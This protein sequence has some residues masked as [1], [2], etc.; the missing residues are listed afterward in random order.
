MMLT[1]SSDNG[2]I[3]E[4]ICNGAVGYLLKTTPLEAVVSAIRE[5]AAGG[6]P[7][8]PGIAR[9]V[10][11]MLHR[12]T[13]AFAATGVLTPQERRLLQ[14]LAEGHSYQDAG[15]HLGVTVNTVRSHVRAIYEKLHVRTMSHAVHKGLR[16]G[17]IQ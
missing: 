4:S 11:T 7:M 10:V 5:A 1:V 16:Q 13:P 12:R 6:A 8:S 3:F 14:L 17:F 2:K 9:R 15:R